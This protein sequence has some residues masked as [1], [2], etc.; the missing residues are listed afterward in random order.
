VLTAALLAEV[1]AIRDAAQEQY[2]GTASLIQDS[3]VPG[4][5]HGLLSLPGATVFGANADRLDVLSADL[6]ARLVRF[7]AMREGAAHLIGQSAHVRCEVVRAALQ[8]LAHSADE[9]LGAR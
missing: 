8:G 4:S 9:V 6:A 5:H 3:P 2:D 1:A 7:H